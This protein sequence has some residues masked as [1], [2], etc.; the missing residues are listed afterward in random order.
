MVNNGF[1]KVIMK[2]MNQADTG[3]GRRFRAKRTRTCAVCPRARP[4]P[5]VAGAERADPPIAPL[6]QITLFHNCT[7]P[8]IYSSASF[9]GNV[10]IPSVWT[11]FDRI[12]ALRPV[13]HTTRLA[14][15]VT[16]W[17]WFT[18]VLYF[19]RNNRHPRIPFKEWSKIV[20]EQFLLSPS[21]VIALSGPYPRCFQFYP[22]ILIACQTV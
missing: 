22:S 10:N 9:E 12:F 19:N 4:R 7:I 16:T 8:R 5:L 13:A 2:K 1:P 21:I 3:C 14:F 18:K 6:H 17:F 20:R 11:M 15:L